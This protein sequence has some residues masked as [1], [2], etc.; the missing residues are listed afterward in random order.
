MTHK[1]RLV[2]FCGGWHLNK[3]VQEPTMTI[4]SRELAVYNM[5][6]QMMQHNML[7]FSNSKGAEL[8]LSPT[9]ILS[10]DIKDNTCILEHTKFGRM[11]L[12]R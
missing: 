7:K 1:E 5:C 8:S 4:Y 10:V 3:P 2:Q 6:L 11:T 9:D 12:I